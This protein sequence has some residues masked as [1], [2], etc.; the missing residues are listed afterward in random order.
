S[1]SHRAFIAASLADGVSII[2][3]PLT[4]GD[5]KTTIDI[6][7]LLGVKILKESENT[8]VIEKSDKILRS[9][10]KIID[11]KNSGTSIRIFSAL[12]LLVEGGLNFT[13][14]FLK[15]GRPIISLLNSLKSLGAEFNIEEDILHIERVNKICNL[16]EIPGDISSQ[17]I[18]ALLIL[19][20]LV[21]CEQKKGIE[22]EISTPLLSYPYIKITL[23][24]LSSFGINVQ[25]K[26]NENKTGKY[27][28][29]CEQKYRPQVY[30][31]PG[32]FS[33]AAFLI[34]ATVISP[35]K[36][37]VVIK[38][39]KQQD[40]Q[41]DKQIIE[42]LKKMGANIQFDQNQVVIKGNLSKYPLEGIDIDC[43]D[44]PDLFP[45]LCVI[46][47]AAKGKTTLYNALHLRNKESDRISIMA[48]ELKKKGV[49]IE[50][51]EDNLTVFNSKLNG[52]VVD[53]EGDHRIA[54]ACCIASLYSDTPSIIKNIEIVK[55]SYPNFFDDLKK[56]GLK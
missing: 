8:F 36:S 21:D 55:D 47:S 27:Y 39:L 22:I 44:I 45:I 25:E 19:S 7:K 28:I 54:M 52:S 51:K 6:L 34:G 56:L 48:R 38:N 12:S 23:D 31:I 24:V 42:I 37:K 20:P 16:V 50:E 43:H 11:C 33:S 40:P 9:Y 15:R 53:P 2:K 49:R 17:F 3:N 46:G 10:D 14:I 32:D 26:L 35:K 30:Q 1:Y 13:G 29:P 18:T 41:G 4:V 5:V